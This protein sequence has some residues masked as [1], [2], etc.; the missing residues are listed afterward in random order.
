MVAINYFRNKEYVLSSDY[1]D[2]RVI[3]GKTKYSGKHKN[4]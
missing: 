2:C 3:K 1:K 4:K